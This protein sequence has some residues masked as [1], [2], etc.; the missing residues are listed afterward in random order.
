MVIRILFFA[1]IV[2]LW[3]FILELGASDTISPQFLADFMSVGAIGA[4]TT[5]SQ[6]HR[7]P[8]GR[9]V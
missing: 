3:N 5:E 2:N 7:E 9:C 4:R 8:A 6:L 1:L